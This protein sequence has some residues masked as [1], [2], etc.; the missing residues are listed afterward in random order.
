MRAEMEMV[1][2]KRN[3]WILAA[4]LAA[5]TSACSGAGATEPAAAPPASVVAV[6]GSPV[7]A[8][9]LT[10]EAESR[11]GIA[12]APAR[13]SLVAPL[14]GGKATNRLVIPY[15]AVVYDRD[16]SSWTYTRTSDHLYLRK[17]ITV[18]FVS[19]AVAVLSKGPAAGTP[20]VT[21]GSPELLGVEYNISGEE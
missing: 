8:V 17:P 10:A 4:V 1:V 7:P 19:G 9:H 18:D 2:V 11:L 6:A 15:A 13:L 12:T 20:V 16:G 21:V 14:N 5:S 3:A